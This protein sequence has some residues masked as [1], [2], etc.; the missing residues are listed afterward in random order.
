MAVNFQNKLIGTTLVCFRVSM[1][2]ALKFK[3]YQCCPN[4]L[5][6]FMTRKRISI[7]VGLIALQG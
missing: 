6:N 5:F 2:E 1:L 3:K 4:S 7:G